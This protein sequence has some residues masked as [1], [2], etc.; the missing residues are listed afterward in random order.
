MATDFDAP[1]NNDGVSSDS[2][3]ELK[4][5][6]NV[7]SASVVDI[8]EFEAAEGLELPGADLSGEELAV[9]VLP[10]L[11]DEFI[12]ASCFLVYHRGQLASGSGAP[13]ICRDCDYT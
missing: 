12:C 11:E 13:S 4:T 7:N 6:R 3:E 9:R 10:Q 2:I 1:R 5:R 8:D